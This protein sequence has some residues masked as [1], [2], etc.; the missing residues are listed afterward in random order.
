M[1]AERYGKENFV[2]FLKEFLHLF[3]EEPKTQ[4]IS[5]LSEEQLREEVQRLLSENSHLKSAKQ[6]LESQVSQLSESRANTELW[7]LS[8]ENQRLSLDLNNERNRSSQYYED[9]EN[10]R[11]ISARWSQLFPRFHK[12]DELANHINLS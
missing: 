7:R 10:Y 1:L 5:N 8:T 11:K 12:L 9:A 2:V 6:S 4:E 3:T